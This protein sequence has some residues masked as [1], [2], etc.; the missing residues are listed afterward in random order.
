MRRQ[1]TPK[2]QQPL[3]KGDEDEQDSRITL[4]SSFPREERLQPQRRCGSRSS[5]QD[6]MQR[7]LL[8]LMRVWLG[9]QRRE[10]EL[11]VRLP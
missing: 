5:G 1:M 4:L 8:Q 9:F 3:L 11:Q 7:T 10:F 2:I 6:A